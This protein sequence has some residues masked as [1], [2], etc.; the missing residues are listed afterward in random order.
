MLAALVG[1]VFGGSEGDA[2][3]DDALD[4]GVIG[5]VQEQHCLV[6]GSVLLKV[7]CRRLS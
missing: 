6:H 4:G 1:Q 5:Q 7:L 2:G 3:G